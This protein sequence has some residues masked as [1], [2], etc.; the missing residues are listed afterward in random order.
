MVITLIIIG[1]IYLIASGFFFVA[2]IPWEPWHV[3]LF[4]SLFYPAIYFG[5]LV[6]MIFQA[7]FKKQNND[8]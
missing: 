3:A 5:F 2:L 1:I 4:N 8:I 6:I 7:I